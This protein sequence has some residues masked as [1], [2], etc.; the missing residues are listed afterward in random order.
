MRLGRH[1]SLGIGF[2][3]HVNK[4]PSDEATYTFIYIFLS[5]TSAFM[6][7]VIYSRYRAF[8]MLLCIALTTLVT[9][10]GRVSRC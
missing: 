7:L 1:S 8:A 10:L 2:R 6:L 3:S 5:C 4:I 9:S